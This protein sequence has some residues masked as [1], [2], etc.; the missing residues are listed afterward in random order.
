MN[1]VLKVYSSPHHPR[2]A[3]NIALLCGVQRSCVH[4]NHY[5]ISRFQRR[6]YN[7]KSSKFSRLSAKLCWVALRHHQLCWNHQW[8]HFTFDHSAFHRRKCEQI[9]VSQGNEISFFNTTGFD[10]RVAQRFPSWRRHLHQ[11]RNHFHIVWK[12]RSAALERAEA[13]TGKRS[14]MNV[15]AR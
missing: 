12:W 9:D 3:S 8:V 2:I 6:S 14:C 15:P 5:I 10:E 11:H 7:H 4:C 13:K 1:S